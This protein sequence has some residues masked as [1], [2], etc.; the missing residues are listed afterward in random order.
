MSV[1]PL[2]N[3]INRG[4]HSLSPLG[5]MAPDPSPKYALVRLQRTHNTIKLCILCNQTNYSAV[6]IESSHIIINS[7]IIVV[8]VVIINSS[9]HHH[10][11]YLSYSK[12][13]SGR[14]K[15]SAFLQTWQHSCPF[16]SIQSLSSYPY[17]LEKPT[18]IYTCRYKPG[19]LNAESSQ[20]SISKIFRKW[21]SFVLFSEVWT[22]SEKLI[23]WVPLN[24][25]VWI[26]L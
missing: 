11:H 18:V 10:R 7:I 26:I 14:S 12:I 19:V 25:K 23:Y 13:Q 20:I 21:D 1:R 5:G 4:N 3:I 17:V 15:W 22:N 24:R 2:S 8:V 16:S 6:Q 9:C